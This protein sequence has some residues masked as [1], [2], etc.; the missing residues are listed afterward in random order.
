MHAAQ[1][2][3]ECKVHAAC[4]VGRDGTGVRWK[5]LCISYNLPSYRK[6]PPVRRPLTSHLRFQ[7]PQ[8]DCPVGMPHQQQHA[9]AVLAHAQRC[10]SVALVTLRLLR[11]A[12]VRTLAADLQQPA[13]GG[14]RG[15]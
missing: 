9:A 8:F 11:V 4:V 2:L 6:P 1:R 7:L 15:G 13:L 12:A 3:G 5:K 14:W 10:H